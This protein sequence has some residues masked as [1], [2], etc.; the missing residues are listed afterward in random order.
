[1][2]E[3][4]VV[5]GI[6]RYWSHRLSHRV[7]WL[8]RFHAVHHS[9]TR[10]DWLAAV[11][12]HPV[13]AVFATAA[14]GLPLFLLGFDRTTLGPWL[15]VTTVGP[16]LDHAN[17]RVRLPGLRWLV[18][19]P[20]WHHWHHATTA[21]SVPGPGG[22][23]EADRAVPVDRNFSPFPW[24]D[25]LFGTAYLPGRRR[26]GGYG[27]DDPIPST[28]YLAQLAHPWRRSEPARGDRTRATLGG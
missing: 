21:A 24:V 7:P 8:W 17:L 9:S 23:R 26:P 6:S 5:V 25:L 3:A 1:M 12:L 4:L 13:D 20:E 2:L 27:I 18:P 19:N 10:L 16:F 11:R 15:V 28:G 14:T 22:R